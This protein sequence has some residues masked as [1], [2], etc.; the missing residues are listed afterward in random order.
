[1]SRRLPSPSEG[2][3]TPP[4]PTLL[5]HCTCFT[6]LANMDTVIPVLWDK[7]GMR[8]EGPRSEEKMHGDQGGLATLD[9]C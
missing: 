4:T 2:A 5:L 8:S 3:D 6:A 7:G 9:T 1:M